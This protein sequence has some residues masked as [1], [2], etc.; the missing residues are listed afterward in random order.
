MGVVHVHVYC[1][2]VYV[3]VH[4]C[5][6]RIAENFGRKNILRVALIMAFGGFYFGDWVSFIP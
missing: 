6:Y 5:T 1:M 2:Y 4:V 3:F